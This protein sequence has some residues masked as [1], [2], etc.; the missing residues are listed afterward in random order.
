MKW[1]KELKSWGAIDSHREPKPGCPDVPHVLH[2]RLQSAKPCSQFPDDLHQD[3]MSQV[4]NSCTVQTRLPERFAL[5]V[6]SFARISAA[7]ALLVLL[8]FAILSISRRSEGAL[9]PATR[10]ED[11]VASIRSPVALAELPFSVLSPLEDEWKR[12]N[13]DMTNAASILLSSVP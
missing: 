9:E 3:I 7:V 12:V 2:Q 8:G 11:L 4:R 6:W 1:F 5:P 10:T 13:Q